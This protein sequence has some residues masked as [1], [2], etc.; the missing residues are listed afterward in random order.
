MKFGEGEYSASTTNFG[1]NLGGGVEYKVSKKIAVG[2]EIKYQI[3]SNY[4][5][6]GLQIGATYLF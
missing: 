6:L 4:G 5:H 3:V 2:A 1:V